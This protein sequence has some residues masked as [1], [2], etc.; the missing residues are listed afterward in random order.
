MPNPKTQ[1]PF[2]S[3]LAKLYDTE[4][5]RIGSPGAE[6]E[7]DRIILTHE[8]G[9]LMMSERLRVAIRQCWSGAVPQ[10]S[11][12]ESIMTDLPDSPV[13]ILGFFPF[14][15]PG[16][17]AV[18]DFTTVTLCAREGN[19]PREMPLWNWS[20]AAT[21]AVYLPARFQPTAGLALGNYQMLVNAFG[22]STGHL[23]FATMPS[24][25]V[26]ANN[27][28]GPRA[29]VDDLVLRGTTSAFGAGTREVFVHV[30]IAFPFPFVE[31]EAGLPVPSW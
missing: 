4:G 18:T 14:T 26:K 6:L 13:R 1:A 8:M 27:V 20:G 16:V 25:I 24:L 2:G 22:V 21:G 19:E 23:P 30:M 17:G 3:E 7:S 28:V 31:G 15:L 10:S 12:F 5:Q 11:T 9:Q 29:S